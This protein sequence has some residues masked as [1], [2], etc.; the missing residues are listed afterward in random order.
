MTTGFRSILT[1]ARLG[2]IAV[3]MTA[4]GT[5]SSSLNPSASATTLMAGWERHFTLEWTVEP[6]PDGARQLDGYVSST[7]GGNAQ[8]VRLLGQALDRAGAIVGQRIVWVPEGVGGF[9]RTYFEIP[10]LPAAD[11]YRV[12]VWDYSF[13]QADL[14]P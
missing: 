3:A 8:S 1:L 12:S 11:H 4:C 2:L 13:F 9:G 6:K 10:D 14:R 5:V 7:Y